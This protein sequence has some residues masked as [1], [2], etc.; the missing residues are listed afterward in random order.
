MELRRKIALATITAATLGTA[1][2]AT[3]PAQA[4]VIVHESTDYPPGPAVVSAGI[5]VHDS[6]AWPPGATVVSA[7]VIVHDATDSP[8]GPTVIS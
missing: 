6:T 7:G 2:L 1:L 4:G 3:A 5:I 8:T